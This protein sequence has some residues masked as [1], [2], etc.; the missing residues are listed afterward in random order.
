MIL[1]VVLVIVVGVIVGVMIYRERVGPFRAAVLEVDDS[2]V[3]MRYFLKRLYV[4]R[5]DPMAVFQALIEDQIIKQT[6]PESPFFIEVSEEDVDQFIAE[7]A[8]GDNET[9]SDAEVEE[10][11]RQRLNETPFSDS[12]FRDLMHTNLLRRTMHDHLSERV[13]TVAEQVHLYVIAQPSL[14][15]A[16]E[17]RNRLEAGEDFLQLAQDE[18]SDERLKSEGGDL[19][20]YPRGV[21]AANLDRVAF[22][23]LDANQ[24]SEPLY[25]G[26]EFYGLILVAERAAARAISDEALQ[27]IR[28]TVLD[29][30]FA[31]EMQ[32]H[33][34][35]L[36][37]LNNGYDSETDAWVNWQLQKMGQ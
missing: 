34:I 5:E 7:I 15:K 23:E 36:H 27:I 12:E 29:K 21:L 25:L 14:D 35:T 26:G 17:L 30:W 28:A 32:N 2:S 11:Y 10:W 20:W 13:P 31:D 6:A 8:T 22:D 18:N 24:V 33:T 1:A 4:S 9:V 3:T 19:G 16:T 37:G